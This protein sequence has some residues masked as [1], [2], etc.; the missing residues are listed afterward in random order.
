MPTHERVEITKNSQRAAVLI[1]ADDYDSI[2]E[3]IAV[4]SDGELLVAHLHRAQGG[5][6][7][8]LLDAGG[9]VRLLKESGPA[10]GPG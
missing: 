9:L 1:G 3:T 4:L 2:M 7:R 10:R 6:R 8:R 5:Q